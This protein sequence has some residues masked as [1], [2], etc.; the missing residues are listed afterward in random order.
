MSII[1]LLFIIKWIPIFL[2]LGISFLD[3]LLLELPIRN[4]TS[5]SLISMFDLLFSC[6]DHNSTLRERRHRLVTRPTLIQTLQ[7]HAF[8]AAASREGLLTGF[9]FPHGPPRTPQG[10]HALSRP[11]LRSRSSQ[12]S[13]VHLFPSRKL[14]L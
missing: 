13:V 5:H 6:A 4:R 14:Y 1:R 10:L 8:H 9:T 11:S 2:S 12:F 7:D 3:E